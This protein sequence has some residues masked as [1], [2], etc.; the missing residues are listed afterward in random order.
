M[1]SLDRPLSVVLA[2]CAV[3][4]E[5]AFAAQPPDVVTSDVFQ[6][7]AMGPSVLL[8]ITPSGLIGAQNTAAGWQA[9]MGD[10]VGSSNTAAGWQALI[11]N[12]S[13]DQNTAVG[14]SA[15]TFNS[16]GGQ[17]VAVGQAALYRNNGSLNTA[18]GWQALNSNT[19]G[20]TNT[21]VGGN[22]LFANSTGLDN[23]AVG[24]NALSVGNGNYNTAV[25]WE[26]LNSNNGDN[27]TATGVQAL[28]AN[29]TG[30]A[31]TGTGFGALY[32]N[33]TGNNNTA[34]GYS[35]LQGNTTGSYNSA[36]GLQALYSNTTGSNN[37]ASGFDALFKNNTGA[38]NTAYGE[39]ALY[40]SAGNYN[41]GVGFDALY[42]HTSGTYNVALGWKA[43]FALTTG[44]NNIDIDN[45]G[46]AGDNDTIRIGTEG[47]QTVTV[48]AGILTNSGASGA[49][50]LIDANG[51]LGVA[52]S[53][54]RFKTAISPM[55]SNTQKLARLQPVTFKY[56]SDP[57]GML[58]YG[59]IAEEV[60]KVYPELV[61]RSATGRIDGVRYDELAPIL[62]NEVQLQ[63]A[64]I[65]D[66]KQQQK[67]VGEMQKELVELHAALLK[68]QA[69]EESLAQ[70]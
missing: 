48:I 33:T 45:Q 61:L 65:R 46:E 2:A 53:S 12:T 56:K 9:M 8:N 63:A 17:N 64:E 47:T 68:F 7:T 55:G 20:N 39:S 23:V 31:N 37:T 1:K 58:R 52:G 36:F 43:G 5:T 27:N 34:S 25:G 29:T 42:H 49:A 67:T 6:N 69:K 28:Y 30:G 26:A 57:T 15:L 16:T 51:R 62:L 19:S 50:V 11:T 40:S 32:R 4:C 3:I 14:S 41:T 10:T 54:E 13:G 21:A 22:A 18:I 38:E 24:Y 35:A 59:L 60:A 44:S 70:R 66:L